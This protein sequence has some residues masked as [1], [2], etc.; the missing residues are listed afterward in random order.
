MTN[1]ADPDQLV[2]KKPTDL[3]LHCLLRQGMSCS[4]R[5]ELKSGH[6][7][8]RCGLKLFFFSIFSSGG[9]YIHPSGTILA[10]LVQGNKRNISL[11]YFESGLWPRC[12]SKIFNI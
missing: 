1:R 5:D 2:L 3:D 8:G 11:N 7:P 10:I 12:R 4:A 9:H 6:S